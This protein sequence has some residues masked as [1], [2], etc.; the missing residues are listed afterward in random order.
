MD[1]LKELRKSYRKFAKKVAVSELVT[2]LDPPGNSSPKEVE[3]MLLRI[4]GYYARVAEL[5]NRAEDRVVELESK[6]DFLYSRVWDYCEKKVYEINIKK[7]MTPNNAKPISKSIDT[8][9]RKIKDKVSKG[10]LNSKM[11]LKLIESEKVLA[12]AKKELRLLGVL[13]KSWD[14]KADLTTS[15][16]NLI[17]NLLKKDMYV[18]TDNDG[19]QRS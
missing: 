11:F 12:E 2:K 9:L 18:F 15:L 13:K 5:Y 4:P 8:M 14:K 6:R 16:T 7:G 3:E 19:F 1:E 10:V 17:G